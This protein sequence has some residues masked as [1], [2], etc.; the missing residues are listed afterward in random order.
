M[1]S[2]GPKPPLSDSTGGKTA[3][4]AEEV[5]GNSKTN[6]AASAAVDAHRSPEL[7]RA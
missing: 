6:E 1:K 7:G 2:L 3:S 4:T 5:A